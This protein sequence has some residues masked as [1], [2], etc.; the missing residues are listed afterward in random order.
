MKK[1]GLIV[2]A[3]MASVVLGG[4]FVAPGTMAGTAEG[5]WTSEDALSL[6]SDAV[7]Q[8]RN[9]IAAGQQQ[10]V[11]IPED[12]PFDYE[13]REK[14]AAAA[15]NWSIAVKALGGAQTSA[16]KI[17]SATSQ[18][19]ADSYDLLAKVNSCVALSGANVVRT[20][21]LF[22]DAVALNKSEALDF[23]RISMRD[24][25]LSSDLV[26]FNYERVK[27]YLMN[28]QTVLAEGSGIVAEVAA[29]SVKAKLNLAH[30]ALTGDIGLIKEAAL[31]ADA[32]DSALAEAREAF[33]E[34]EIELQGQGSDAE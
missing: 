1:H 8:A 20:G 21:L 26:Q 19:V 5:M 32:I 15:D 30:A 14:L 9:A 27:T 7:D 28:Q 6:A 22:V 3:T 23:I 4:L 17:G 31:R 16:S 12:S 2:F 13:I 34:L 11:K 33:A 24:A 25:L 29:L 10:V 18:E